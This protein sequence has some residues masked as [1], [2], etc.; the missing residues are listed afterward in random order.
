[1]VSVIIPR[2]EPLQHTG[3]EILGA[4]L[5]MRLPRFR[6]RHLSDVDVFSR[7]YEYGFRSNIDVTEDAAKGRWSCLSAAN[8]SVAGTLLHNRVV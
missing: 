6:V 3:M 5:D 4:V 7:D 2:R 1:M 8:T